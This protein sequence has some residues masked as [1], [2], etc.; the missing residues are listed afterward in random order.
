MELF[1]PSLLNDL[2]MA[3]SVISPL[4]VNQ[5]EINIM[6]TIVAVILI[7][8]CGYSSTKIIAFQN[9]SNQNMSYF[10]IKHYLFS[11]NITLVIAESWRNDKYDSFQQRCSLEK[12]TKFYKTKRS[13]IFEI[14]KSYL[15]VFCFKQRIN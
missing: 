10:S 2:S 6:E 15:G 3:S 14:F 13:R 12:D 11:I 5:I 9:K 7:F 4:N 8:I 1:V